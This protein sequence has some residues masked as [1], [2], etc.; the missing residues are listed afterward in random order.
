MN[1]IQKG[2]PP[3]NP[4]KIVF[5]GSEQHL[6]AGGIAEYY[7]SLGGYNL[8]I[9]K[10]Y[11]AVFERCIN[12]ATNIQKKE[13]VMIGDN[14]ETGIL[15][16]NNIGLQSLFVASGVHKLT[17]KSENNIYHDR[18]RA[19]QKKFGANPTYVVPN[20]RW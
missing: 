13:T 10:P 2:E 19:S 16:A 9:G 6:R 11:P 5:R 20:L 4:D 1:A 15:G 12:M 17:N 14:L 18:L 7:E 8:S 3:A